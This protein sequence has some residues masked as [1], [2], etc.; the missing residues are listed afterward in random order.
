[1]EHVY[2]SFYTKSD[3]IVNY[4]AR[5]L[6]IKPGLRVLEPCAGDGVFVDALL[7]LSHDLSIDIYELNP[8]AVSILRKAFGDFPNIR[9]THGDTISDEHLIFYSDAGGIYDRVIANPP[10]GGL[11]DYEKRKTL[12]KM[13]RG[14]YVKETYALFLYRCILVF[15]EV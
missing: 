3:P 15:P 13:Y 2:Q 6:E 8:E 12:K 4:M 1:M 14:L 11:Q 10:Y 9:I 5:Q 7:N